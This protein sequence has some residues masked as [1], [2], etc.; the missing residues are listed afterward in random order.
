[1]AATDTVTARQRALGSIVTAAMALPGVWAEPAQAE[2]APEQ[3]VIAFKQLRYEDAQPGL[4]RISVNAPS[5]YVLLPLGAHW[6]MEASGVVDNVSGA[7][8]RWHSAVSGASVMHEERKAFD[9][10]LTRYMDRA[11]WS[12]GLS[13][14]KEHDYLSNALSADVSLSSED[15]NTTWN[16]GLGLS[17]D[18]INPTNE[19]VTDERKRTREFMVGV[20][21]ALSPLDLVQLNLTHARGSGYYNDPYKFPD[22]RPRERQQTALL[23]RWNHHFEDLGATLRSSYRYYRDSYRIKAHTLQAEWVQP[24]SARWTLT[25]LLRLYSQSAASFYY[26]PVYDATLGEPMPAGYDAANPPTYLSADQ[27]LSAFGGVTLGLKAEFQW[28]AL[29][30]ADLSVQRYEQ[31]GEWRVGGTGSPGLAPFR[32]SFLQVGVNRKF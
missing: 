16:L 23:L 25:P 9:V 28:D 6:A 18:R 10:K 21:Q 20:T 30:S 2:S 11:T 13:R 19:V 7:T 17:R 29:W 12:L 5:L 31:R 8:P 3:G 22:S 14:S 4:D 15:H 27:R 1:M 24:V 32:A 26:D